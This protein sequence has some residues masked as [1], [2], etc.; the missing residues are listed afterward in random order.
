MKACDMGPY[1]LAILPQA[2]IGSIHVPSNDVIFF[3]FMAE[4]NTTGHMPVLL[5]SIHLLTDI[6]ANPIN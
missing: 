3:F 4:G 1:S 2:I 5:L 6:L